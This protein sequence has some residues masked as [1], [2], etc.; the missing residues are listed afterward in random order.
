MKPIN[1]KELDPGQL[2]DLRQALVNNKTFSLLAARFNFHSSMKYYSPKIF[3]QIR[4]YVEEAQKNDP[5]V[6]GL[7]D[8]MV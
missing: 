1:G 2:S 8:D 4:M 5:T 6:V 7:S 3:S